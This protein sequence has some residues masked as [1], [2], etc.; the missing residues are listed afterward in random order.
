[1]RQVY[2][3]RLKEQRGHLRKHS[4]SG[5][6]RRPELS[7]SFFAACAC[8]RW[9]NAVKVLEIAFPR[10][11]VIQQGVQDV[12]KQLCLQ[13]GKGQSCKSGGPR[14]RRRNHG[15][16]EIV[17]MGRF[18]GF[19]HT[20]RISCHIATRWPGPA[21]APDPVNE[22]STESVG[23]EVTRWPSHSRRRSVP[24]QFPHFL[25]CVISHLVLVGVTI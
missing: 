18:F 25:V 23:G 19:A 2:C 16:H 11:S 10:L 12:E 7:A 9:G 21:T 13:T 22:G 17:E 14:Q 6:P 8:Q 20:A 24:R 1:M 3:L 5:C 15:G 4:L